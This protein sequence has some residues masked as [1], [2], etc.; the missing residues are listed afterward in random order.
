MSSGIGC[1]EKLRLIAGY[2]KSRREYSAAI[3]C[4]VVRGISQPE[5]DRLSR[6]TDNARHRYRAARH[7]LARH[8]GLLGAF[9]KVGRRSPSLELE[10]N[11]QA[12][13]QWGIFLSKIH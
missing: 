1:E 4:M 8:I 10:N 11:L 7:Q 6:E 12:S 5:Y 9:D 13:S 3:G 2:Q